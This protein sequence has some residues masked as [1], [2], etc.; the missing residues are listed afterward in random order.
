M[1]Q[2]DPIDDAIAD[3]LTKL[4]TRDTEILLGPA[5]EYAGLGQ[6]LAN[7]L[8]IISVRM[9]NNSSKLKVTYKA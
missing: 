5:E 9:D 3:G 8:Y 6:L 2:I 4:M 1:I 7:T